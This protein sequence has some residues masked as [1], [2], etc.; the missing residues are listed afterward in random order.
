MSCFSYRNWR[1]IHSESPFPRSI[2]SEIQGVPSWGHRTW[3]RIRF[4]RD[5]FLA[6]DSS[7]IM[8]E[9]TDNRAPRLQAYQAFVYGLSRLFCSLRSI[10]PHLQRCYTNS[11][12]FLGPLGSSKPSSRTPPQ[13]GLLSETVYQWNALFR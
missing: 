13:I 6:Q 2:V 8:L 7:T 9:W 3:N 4:I 12:S 11:R 10:K 1:H 5:P